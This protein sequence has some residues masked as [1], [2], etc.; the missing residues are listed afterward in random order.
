MNILLEKLKLVRFDVF[1]ELVHA[2][3]P[4][5]FENDNGEIEEFYF[6]S[7]D[8]NGIKFLYWMTQ[9]LPLMRLK[10]FLQMP[11]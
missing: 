6:Q 11:C 9:A 5:C 1:P 3:S 4:R 7:N 8:R 10:K 2:V